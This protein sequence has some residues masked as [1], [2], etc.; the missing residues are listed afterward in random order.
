MGRE[1]SKVKLSGVKSQRFWF[2][3]G[4]LLLGLIVLPSFSGENEEIGSAQI[5]FEDRTAASGL[6]AFTLVSG[7]PEKNYIVE[8]M[9]GGVCLLDYDG[10]G[11]LDIYFVN[12]GRLRSFQDNAPSGL[13]HA[14]YRNQADG[15]F[16]DVT[17]EAG[18]EGNGAWGYGC[19]AADYDNDGWPDLYVTN[20]GAN[21]LY[22]NRGD[23]RFEDVT[24][25]AGIDDPRWSTGAAWGDYNGDGWADLFVAN[26]IRLDRAN[27]PEPGS[28]E[29]GSMG[30]GSGCR[31]EGL[32]VMCGPRG[33]PG[34]GDTLFRNNGDGTFTDVSQ[35]AGLDDPDEYYGLGAV[36]CDFDADGWLDLYVAND[37]TPNYLYRNRGDGT[38]EEIGFLSGTAVSGQGAEQAGMGVACGDYENSG[39]MAIYVTNFADDTNSLYRNDGQMNFQDVTFD[40]G[41]GPVTLSFV[42][43][44]TFFFDADND[45]WLDLFVANG[46]VYPQVEN[47][48]GPKTYR[49]RS[50]LFRN[51]GNGRFVEVMA[52]GLGQRPGVNRGAVFGD[53]DND[54]DLDVVLT[55]LDERPTLLWNRTTPPQNFLILRLQGTRSTRD[56]LGTRVRLR[57]GSRWQTREVRAGGSYLSSHD[58]RLHFG[59]GKASQVDEIQVLW[60]SGA[61][62]VREDIGA[63]QFLTLRE[64]PN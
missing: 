41:L 6:S 51:Q 33:L 8:A 46:H 28:S 55:S 3:P 29:Y 1:K 56:A 62:S 38:F 63:N 24:A 27:L 32:A 52:E 49:E 47:L 39:R 37:S 43:W 60:P 4:M 17:T 61:T 18:V 44:G 64:P 30:T 5:A 23:G 2:A 15:T 35:E 25:T 16:R 50:L 54:G 11:F 7:T 34:A 48:S 40:A 12:G 14:L 13:R 42:S 53:L 20:Y 36:W 57:T 45:G 26:Y 58:P 22:R 19:S 21:I 59:L 10:D 31:Y 9:G